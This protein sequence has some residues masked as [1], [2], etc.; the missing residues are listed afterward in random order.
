MAFSDPAGEDESLA[1]GGETAV[2]RPGNVIEA[3]EDSALVFS[4]SVIIIVLFC[5]LLFL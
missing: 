3:L 5:S 4:G 1:R 2:E